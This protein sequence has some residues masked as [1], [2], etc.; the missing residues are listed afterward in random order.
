MPAMHEID[1]RIIGDDMQFVEVE[2]DPAEA[3]VAEAG[4]LM[5]MEDGIEMETIFGDGSQ[6]KSGFLGSLMGAGKRL[7]TGESLFMT[8]FLNRA[9]GKRKLAFGAPVL[10]QEELEDRKKTPPVHAASFVST[11]A[12]FTWVLLG[13]GKPERFNASWV[14]PMSVLGPRTVGD[15]VSGYADIRISIAD[16]GGSSSVLSKASCPPSCRSSAAM[17]NTRR[18]ASNGR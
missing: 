13:G 10:V 14:Y 5:Y 15:K 11:S 2:L 7:L 16:E 12:G 18:T 8:V 17:M 1:Y 4:G 3:M 9:N 6:Q